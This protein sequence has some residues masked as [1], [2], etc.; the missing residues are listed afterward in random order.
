MDCSTGGDLENFV[1]RRRIY[2][3]VA[4]II[5]RNVII[6]VARGARACLSRAQFS[7]L[8]S[9]PPGTCA[10]VGT[11]ISKSLLDFDEYRVCRISCKENCGGD[12]QKSRKRVRFYQ[13]EW[14]RKGIYIWVNCSSRLQGTLRIIFTGP[15]CARSWFRRRRRRISSQKASTNETRSIACNT[16]SAQQVVY[17]TRSLGLS[18]SSAIHIHL[19][20]S[21]KKIFSFCVLF[22]T[23]NTILRIPIA[24]NCIYRRALVYI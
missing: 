5:L 23:I 1:I 19:I 7:P 2:D 16:G 12:S 20:G 9:L 4:S 10:S 3:R 14:K 13:K 11:V 24:F 6:A 18:K 17:N 22:M 21:K 15:S 8:S